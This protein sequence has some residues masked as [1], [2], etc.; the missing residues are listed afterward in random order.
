[1]KKRQL[2]IAAVAAV[3]SVSCVYADSTITGIT[4]PGNTSGVFDIN[5]EKINGGV[6]Y[7]A[8]EDFIL[9]NGDIANLLYGTNGARNIETFINLVK[10]GVEINGILNTVRDGNFY[11][12]HAVFVTPGGLTIG[13][14][15]VLNVGTLSVATP[16]DQRYNTLLGEYNNNNFSNISNVS[17]LLNGADESN[18][19]DI[20]VDGKVFA[21]NGVQLR[22]GQ[23]DVGA[24]GAIING[25]AQQ[26]AFTQKSQADT[27]FNSLVNTQGMVTTG[28]QFVANGSNIQIKSSTGMDIAGKVI[29][30]AAIAGKD[31]GVNG[32][33]G[34]NGL[35]LTN[36]GTN[37]TKISGLLQSTDDLNVYNKAG[38]LNISG[39]VKNAND[40]LEISNKGTNLTIANGANLTTDG[41]LDIANNGTG[42]LTINGTAQSKGDL[43]IYNQ[44]KGTNLSVGGNVSTTN[45]NLAIVNN[46]KGSLAISG[47]AKANAGK[48]DVVNE[49]AGGM[50]ITGIVSGAT[51]PK[52]GFAV[53][54][55]NR[56]GKMVISNTSDK[57]STDHKVRL[58]NTGADGMEIAGVKAGEHVSIENK[59]GDLTI[60]GKISVDEGDMHIRNS[61]ANGKLTIAA[62]GNV[63]GEKLLSIRNDGTGGMEISGN[64][65]N[66]PVDPSQSQTAINNY[67]GN[68][69]VDGNI[70]TYGNTAVKN[71]ATTNSSLTINGDITTE[72]ELK[73]KNYG[74]NGMTIAGNVTAIDDGLT[75]YNDGGLLNINGKLE[76]QGGNLAVWS[77]ENSKGIATGTTSKIITDD[78]YNI[79]IKHSGSTTAGSNGMDLKGTI[80]SGGETAI[81]NY[82]GNM[83]VAGTITSEGNMGIINRQGGGSMTTGGKISSDLA[84]INIKNYGSGDMTVNSEISHSGR[85]NVLANSGKLNLGAKVHNNGNGALDENNGFYAAAR[86]DKGGTHG[87]GIAVTE[88][89]TADGTGQN[90]IKNI[91]GEQGLTY[92]GNINTSNGQTELYNMKG[93]MTVGGEI[94]TA[95]GNAVILNKGDNLTVNGTITSDKD[96]KVVNKGTANADITEAKIEAPN[97]G[98]KWFWE[99]LRAKAGI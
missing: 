46:G 34:L 2:F 62:G 55:V 66:S 13:A 95:S 82:S 54:I 7:R 98:I 37:G 19:G 52:D 58:E 60:N 69:T 14:S 27:L 70:E 33:N 83:N 10:N 25:V 72:G 92:E 16:T 29:N 15:G 91:S 44:A 48:T 4:G 9:G 39:T 8:Y 84:N 30:G 57:V 5:P 12:G 50:N 87:T 80:T 47:T 64:V 93:D 18:V 31:E 23:I 68:M 86:E 56:G 45:G 63:Q 38:E 22:G 21:R 96:V 77:R 75:V 61:S 73:V 59:A 85:V 65:T 49:G 3:L 35:Y 79:A 94:N 97:K 32:A 20:T 41:E 78:G 1:M 28:N 89:F 74:T 40:N 53:R 43:N 6:G 24:N 51:A 17:H 76:T 36:N 81:N 99:Q 71:N 42:A 90:L 11:N 88:G 26:Q 67:A